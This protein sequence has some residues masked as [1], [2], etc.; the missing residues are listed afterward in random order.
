[1]YSQRVLTL[2]PPT[3]FSL[4][5]KGEEQSVIK[6]PLHEGEGYRVRAKMSGNP[7]RDKL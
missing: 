3:P 1:M 2:I 6:V 7:V 5:A 4:R